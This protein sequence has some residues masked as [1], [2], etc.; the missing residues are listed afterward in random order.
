MHYT[1]FIRYFVASE[2]PWNRLHVLTLSQWV[3][4]VVFFSFKSKNKHRKTFVI[5]FSARLLNYT[6]FSSIALSPF[7][8]FLNSYGLGFLKKKP[9]T[10]YL[11]LGVVNVSHLSFKEWFPVYDLICNIHIVTAYY[12]WM[13]VSFL[14]LMVLR[15][16]FNVV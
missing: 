2:V 5:Y 15:G 10:S 3:A 9:K 12:E 1:F 13:L 4:F 16:K 6:R 8:L 14:L 11:K 7:L